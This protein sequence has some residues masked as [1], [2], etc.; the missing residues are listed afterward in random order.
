MS[1]DFVETQA[2]V[3]THRDSFSRTIKLTPGSWSQP[4]G[5]IPRIMRALSKADRVPLWLSPERNEWKTSPARHNVSDRLLHSKARID[6]MKKPGRSLKL[7]NWLWS[8]P[9]QNCI[10]FVIWHNW[11]LSLRLYKARN[12][13]WAPFKQA[14]NLWHTSCSSLKCIGSKVHRKAFSFLE[15]GMAKSCYCH[16]SNPQKT[17]RNPI[18]FVAFS[19]FAH[20]FEQRNECGRRDI[21]R[22]TRKT[23]TELPLRKGKKRRSQDTNPFF[24]GPFPARWFGHDCNVFHSIYSLLFRMFLAIKIEFSA[25]LWT[26]KLFF[27]SKIC[28]RKWFFFCT[29]SNCEF[30]KYY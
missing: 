28:L 4:T 22:T 15:I 10:V 21:A 23:Y 29:N 7:Y 25:S 14:C 24:I 3:K 2:A 1:L 30:I 12:G 11:W 8:L 18:T 20:V 6:R 16:V 19:H 26:F 9:F 13:H 17:Q 5:H 27:E